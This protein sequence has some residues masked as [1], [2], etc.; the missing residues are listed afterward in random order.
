MENVSPGE[1]DLFIYYHNMLETVQG[2]KDTVIRKILS[3]LG[4]SIVIDIE[5][6]SPFSIPALP[7]AILRTDLSDK[8]VMIFQVKYNN[9][10]SLSSDWFRK[11]DLSQS[12]TLNV[13]EIILVHRW[14]HNSVFRRLMGR[15]IDKP[16]YFKERFEAACR[17]AC[18]VAG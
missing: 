4:Y 8:A 11:P 7:F 5:V 12:E 13:L 15:L 10:T 16:L 14:M 2:T 17:C 18:K 6:D 9:S 3:Y 1:N